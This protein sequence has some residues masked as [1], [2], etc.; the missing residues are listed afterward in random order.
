ML[1]HKKPE[2][3]LK[4][5]LIIL[6]ENTTKNA[7]VKSVIVLNNINVQKEERE[8]IINLIYYKHNMIKTI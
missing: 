1:L 2:G 6:K 3:K 8:S 4:Q 7:S 5:F